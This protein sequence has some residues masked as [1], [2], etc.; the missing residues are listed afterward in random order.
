MLPLSSS[1]I[2]DSSGSPRRLT[3]STAIITIPEVQYPHW[4]AWCCRKAACMGWREAP[5]GASPSMLVTV[6]PSHCNASIVHDFMA[7]PSTCTT[8]APHWVV[9]HP[10]CVP[11]RP[12]CSRRN[13]TNSVRPST[14]RRTERPLTIIETS[15]MCLPSAFRLLITPGGGERTVR[16]RR[17][18]SVLDGAPD[19]HWRHR[20]R[21]LS[22]AQWCQRVQHRVDDGRRRTDR[23]SLADASH[24]K[25]VH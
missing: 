4:S 9:S 1:R 3:M 10:T 17:L 19:M 14:V 22:H 20:H 8:Q 18:S 24:S 12:R 11:V 21:N 16:L 15:G 5:G 23:G 2:V 7:L 13:S 25:R 6:A